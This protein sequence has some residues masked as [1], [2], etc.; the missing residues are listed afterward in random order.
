M[1]GFQSVTEKKEYLLEDLSA[2]FEAEGLTVTVN[3]D[4]G[5]MAM[6]SS[7]LFGGDSS[8]LTDEGKA[9][10]NKFIKAYSSVAYSDKYSGFISST[11]V[12]G[13]TAPV[14]G[15]TYAGDLTLSQERA[16]NVKNYILSGETGV[17]LS[18]KANNFEAIGC[19]ISQPVYKED[20]SVDMD[21]SRRVSF[22]FLI[23]VNG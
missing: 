19:S 15:S 17:D 23:N 10:L 4:T 18:E 16:D 3:R 9:L 8:A 5:E 13:H 6:D 1:K 14:P 12:E 2:A 22:R 21:A 7:V 20:G 11:M